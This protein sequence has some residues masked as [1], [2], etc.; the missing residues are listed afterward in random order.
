MPNDTYLHIHPLRAGFAR[1]LDQLILFFLSPALIPLGCCIY[2]YGESW[3][4]GG[5]HQSAYVGCFVL[6][7]NEKEMDLYKYQQHRD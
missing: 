2:I 4:R 5:S 3:A 7:P 6:T 1:F